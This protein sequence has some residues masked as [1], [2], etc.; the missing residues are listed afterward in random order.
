MSLQTNDVGEFFS[1]MEAAYGNR[2]RHG[3][4]AVPVWQEGLNRFDRLEVLNA[5]GRAIVEHPDFPPSLGQIIAICN[6]G[7]PRPRPQQIEG[8]KITRVDRLATVV[9]RDAIFLSGGVS[10]DALPKMI[11]A[12]SRFVAK[13]SDPTGAD[14]TNLRDYLVRIAKRIEERG[15]NGD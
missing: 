8:P 2:W 11:A 14:L 7:R 6:A 4:D 15:E 3:A 12:K 13:H 1:I 10:K 9:M 5:A